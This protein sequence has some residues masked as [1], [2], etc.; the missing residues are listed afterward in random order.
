MGRPPARAGRG[1]APGRLAARR[2]ELTLL[3]ELLLV[4]AA[5]VRAGRRR[6]GLL[7]VDVLPEDLV[8]V[9]LRHLV[10][11]GE[12]QALREPRVR[13]RVR[14]GRG[15]VDVRRDRVVGSS[16]SALGSNAS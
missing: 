12:R 8:E 1:R 11:R 4:L 9:A 2:H 13:R 6:L 10:G 16:L 14:V 7:A 3:L 5:R 15:Q